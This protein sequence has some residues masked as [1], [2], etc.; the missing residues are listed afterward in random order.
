LPILFLF[1]RHAEFFGCN[2]DNN[3]DDLLLLLLGALK[4]KFLVLTHVGI[5]WFKVAPV[6][7]QQRFQ[8]A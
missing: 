7:R 2:D 3:D 4:R 1:L 6:V 8:G 5:H